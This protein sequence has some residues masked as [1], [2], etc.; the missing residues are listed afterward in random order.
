MT[1]DVGLRLAAVLL[2]LNGVGFGVFTLPAMR[3]LLTDR[4]VPIVMGFKAYGGGPFECHGLPTTVWLLAAF[5]LVCVAECVAGL[6]LW[7]SHR[8]GAVLALGLLPFAGLSLVG[9][10]AAVWSASRHPRD[11]P[12]PS[13]L[14][15]PPLG[16]RHDAAKAASPTCSYALDAACAWSH[17]MLDETASQDP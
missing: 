4:D 5:L 10:R 15:Q 14:A 11:R 12:H 8:G 3:N 7:N 17:M 1:A 13:Q 9:L 16:E 6:L 2:R